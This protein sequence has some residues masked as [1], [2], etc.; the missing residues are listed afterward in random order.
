MVTVERY[1]THRDPHELPGE[2]PDV[3]HFLQHAGSALENVMTRAAYRSIGQAVLDAR[4]MQPTV[5]RVLEAASEALGCDYALLY[6]V[7]DSRRTAGV[8]AGV[9]RPRARNRGRRRGSRSPVA[10]LR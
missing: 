3:L 9:G 4:A 7:D 1:V 6:L 8:A 2:L 10:I 5:T